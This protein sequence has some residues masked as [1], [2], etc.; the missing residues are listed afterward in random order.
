MRIFA[1]A[2]HAPT[3]ASCPHFMFTP[4]AHSSCSHSHLHL[5][6]HLRAEE[7]G[8]EKE[9]RLAYVRLAADGARRDTN[10]YTTMRRCDAACS[11]RVFT[12]LALLAQAQTAAAV[13]L[14]RATLDQVRLRHRTLHHDASMRHK[15][16]T[17]YS[18][19]LEDAHRVRRRGAGGRCWPRRHRLT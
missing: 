7:E 15:A 16:F 12:S 19:L 4:L 2:L 18:H 13:S 10:R 17:L 3:N 14:M 9:G 5:Y 8:H 11:Q 6:S 1:P